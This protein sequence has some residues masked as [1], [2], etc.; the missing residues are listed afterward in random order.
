MRRIMAQGLPSTSFLRPYLKNIQHK[1]QGWRSGSSDCLASE[2][3]LIQ[4]S[5]PPK[6][7]KNQT[8]NEA[9]VSVLQ[10]YQYTDVYIYLNCRQYN[11]MSEIYRSCILESCLTA[12]CFK[13]KVSLIPATSY[14]FFPASRLI[15]LLISFLPNPVFFFPLKV[16]IFEVSQ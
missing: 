6:K 5:V 10:M 1:K 7:P 14:F 16:L 2:R 11:V 4:T 15:W 3:P 9:L 13:K 12:F 8:K